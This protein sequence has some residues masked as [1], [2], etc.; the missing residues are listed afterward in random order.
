MDSNKLRME[1]SWQTWVGAL[2]VGCIVSFSYPYI[3]LKLGMGPN[4]SVVSA[5][6]GAIFLAITA[7]GSRGQNRFRNNMIQAA[8][9]AGA[10]TAFM[11]I[12][13]A[14]FGY[15]EM[16]KT[17][18]IS[19][20]IDPWQM[21]FWLCCTGWIGV[22]LTV[23]F[24]R[25]FMEDPK[26]IFPDGV[27]AAKTV[28]VLDTPE[29]DR[30]S[31]L[32]KRSLGLGS[33]ASGLLALLRGKG[34]IP[35]ESFISLRDLVG[36][37]WNL[38]SFGSGMLVSL[39]MGISLLL[40]TALSW[41]VIWPWLE[42]SGTHLEIMGLSILA[43][44]FSQCKALLPQGGALM[45]AFAAAKKASAVPSQDAAFFAANCG[46]MI[47]YAQGA[48]HFGITVKWAM[49]PA[50]VMMVFAMFTAILMKWRSIVEAFRQ[51]RLAKAGSREDV[52]LKTIVIGTVILTV[53]LAVL[54]K[55]N[56]GMSYVQTMVAVVASLPLMLV[57][58]R[59]L[60]ETNLGPVSAMA[61]ALQAVFAV[62]WH[63]Q[64]ALNLI[65][66]GISGN[67]SSQGEGGMQDFRAAKIVGSTPRIMTYFQLFG[68][69]IGAAAVALM[70][71]LLVSHYG[72][73]GE[74]LSAPTAVK[75]SGV[76]VLLSKGIGALPTGALLWSVIAAF[77]GIAMAVAAYR[78]EVK[79]IPSPA[80][81][82]FALILPGLLNIP[83]AAGAIFAYVW[84]KKNKATFD[85]YN[86][87]VASGFILGDAIIAGIVLPVLSLL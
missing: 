76:A 48:P 6:L 40:G 31:R 79:W 19:T 85:A 27:A 22:L 34:V 75:I 84:M 9:T 80:G 86:I 4:I 30:E 5:F 61:N 24:R 83:M 63:N 25:M 60:G 52:S 44:H 1:L 28:L 43:E 56:F 66:A 58:I 16:N 49:W 26:M 55:A 64:I 29:D 69:P 45:E 21:F 47:A 12:I 67:I 41:L 23:L 73:G 32:Q 57:G 65:G 78:Y 42:S 68:V 20:K 8:G 82:G 74:G 38:L 53:V 46:D 59:V 71:P 33:L 14:S 70:Y 35:A 36:V 15:L 13:A 3:V 37:E 54:Q 11:C 72:L 2:I 17:V 39:N 77:A 62:F 81:F 7:R 18:E 10:G 87:T 51:L 50:T